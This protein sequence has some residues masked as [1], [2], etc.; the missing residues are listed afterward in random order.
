MNFEDAWRDWNEYVDAF[1]RVLRFRSQNP[2][3]LPFLEFAATLFE[4]ARSDDM[5]ESLR[6][7]VLGESDRR[8]IFNLPPPGIAYMTGT[9]PI[10][11]IFMEFQAFSEAVDRAEN[12][13]TS[14]GGAKKAFKYLLRAAGIVADSA[15]EAFK[16]SLFGSAICKGLKELADLFG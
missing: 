16:D 1:E 12:A 5:R 8:R 9:D 14:E 10:E 4:R 13:V 3:A 11:L 7:L 2:L 15:S 6:T